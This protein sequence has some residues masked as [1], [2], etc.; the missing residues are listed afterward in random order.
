MKI[1][2]VKEGESVY[3]IAREYGV[4]PLKIIEENEL[5][6]P[7]SLTVG[8]ELLIL[9][10]TRSYTVREGDSVKM[11]C[12]RFLISENELLR[13]NPSLYGK[14]GLYKGQILTLKGDTPPY[15]TAFSIGYFYEGTRKEDLCRV[16]PYLSYVVLAAARVHMDDVR[17]C[18]DESEPVRQ[19]LESG[20]IPLLRLYSDTADAL[21][22]KAHVDTAILLARARGYKGICLAIS[23]VRD[24]EKYSCFLHSLK[25]TLLEYGL[26][27]FVE[28]DGNCSKRVEDYYDGAIISYSKL[29]ENCPPDF[30]SG[31]RAVLSEFAEHYE[32]SK[33]FID[34]FPFACC[35]GEFIPLSL[36]RKLYRGAHSEI[37]YDEKTKLCSFEFTKHTLT[38]KETKRVVFESLENVKAK[39]SLIEE[40]GFMGASVDIG[41]T[42]ITHLLMLDYCFRSGGAWSLY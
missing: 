28:L 1:H 27:L 2:R 22:S 17:L 14:N 15:S 34:L 13:K 9:T 16:L 10:P 32:S 37:T 4:S 12:R 18:F 25:A 30:E 7:D 42:P 38:K 40:L 39:L 31:E 36:A 33:G 41:R 8:E 5:S 6:N 35:E 3:S 19:I 24:F 20:K 21:L 23:G 26:C 11:I 29:Q